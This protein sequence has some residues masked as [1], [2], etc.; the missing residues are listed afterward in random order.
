MKK[1]FSVLFVT[2]LLVTS[3]SQVFADEA[4][5]VKQDP[6]LQP[7]GWKFEGGGLVL[8]STSNPS[9]NFKNLYLGYAIDARYWQKCTDRDTS[10]VCMVLRASL[11]LSFL[12]NWADG[13]IGEKNNT[14]I[15][16]VF[17]P[18][19][20]LMGKFS[21]S[22]LDPD[23]SR[24]ESYGSTGVQLDYLSNLG[25]EIEQ[26]L[27][28]DVSLGFH[29]ASDVGAV[30]FIRWIG[31]IK[32]LLGGGGHKPVGASDYYSVLHVGTEGMIGLAFDIKNGSVVL[33]HTAQVNND[34]NFGGEKFN[35]FFYK[36]QNRAKVPQFVL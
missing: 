5:A 21:K 24:S 9:P 14:K 31:S 26:R 16:V 15:N 22:G 27:V 8:D 11:D 2:L 7:V 4:V 18:L 3:F 34:W 30:P 25:L 10:L 29:A 23:K 17:V 35:A 1:K 19:E 33:K 13:S 6:K 36:Q 28:A 12:F 32:G 20:F